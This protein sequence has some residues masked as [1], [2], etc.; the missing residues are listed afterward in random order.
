[1]KEK[2]KVSQ[3]LKDFYYIGITQFGVKVKIVWSDNGSEFTSAPMKTFHR[4][5]GI[6]H[7]RSY[8]DTPQHNGRIE[9]KQHCILNVARALR[10]QANLPIE[11]WGE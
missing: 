4:E 1:M 7:Q 3:L 11:C 10:F 8:V 5:Q 9:R 2:S 6:I